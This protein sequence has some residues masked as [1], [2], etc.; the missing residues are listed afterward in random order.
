MHFRYAGV[1]MLGVVFLASACGGGVPPLEMTQTAIV[2]TQVALS[3][4]PTQTALAAQ[5]AATQTRAARPGVAANADWTPVEQDFDGVT[6]VLVP[7]GCFEMGSSEA[8]ADA[9]FAQCERERGQGQC[10]SDWFSGELP[11]HEQCFDAPF[12]IDKFEVTNA[13]FAEF[14]GTAS[15]DS[16]WT[17]HDLPRE[18]ITWFESRDFCALRGA[19]LP[20]E[21]EWEYAARGPDGLRY[22]WGNAYNAGLVIGLDDPTYGDFQTAPVGSR[23]GGASWVGALD[24]SGNVFEWT[25]SLYAEYPYGADHESD[26]DPESHRVLR[27]GSFVAAT[28]VMRSADRVWGDPGVDFYGDGFRCARSYE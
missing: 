23:P 19:R 28:L 16:N 17:A 5:V 10:Q 22:P 13:Q 14:G 18:S 9:A 24:M 25:S 7:A 12:W 21:A 26:S 20:T 8:E 3:T 4:G 11:A 27:G 15:S 2:R 1:V 6:M